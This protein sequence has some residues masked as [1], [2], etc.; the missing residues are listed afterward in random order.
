MIPYFISNGQ[1]K[2]YVVQ[3]LNNNEELGR[4]PYCPQFYLLISK[5]TGNVKKDYISLRNQSARNN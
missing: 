4:M 2:K 1:S 5:E 3:Y